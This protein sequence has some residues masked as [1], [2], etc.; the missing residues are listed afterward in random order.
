MPFEAVLYAVIIEIA[1]F[2]CYLCGQN[3]IFGYELFYEI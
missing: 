2:F 3:L 1:A